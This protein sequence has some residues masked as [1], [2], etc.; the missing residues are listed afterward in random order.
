MVKAYEYEKG[1]YEYVDED[2]HKRVGHWE[3]KWVGDRD[4][5]SPGD[6]L[7]NRRKVGMVDFYEDED[8]EYVDG[9]PD[10]RKECPHCLEYGVHVKLGAKIKKPGEKPAVDDDKFRSCYQCGNTFPAHEIERE[11]F[12]KSDTEHHKSDNEFEA[13]ESIIMSVP[14]RSSLDGKK[15]LENRKRERQ[16]AH[17][18]DLEIDMEIQQHGEENVHVVYDSD[19]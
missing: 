15:L 4:Y 16:R 10:P 14:S 17:H 1:L 18:K 8:D 3:Q 13:K 7:M 5:Y 12:L 6:K 9:R 2:G 11:K 19:P